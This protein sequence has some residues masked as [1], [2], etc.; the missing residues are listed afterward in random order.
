M[1]SSVIYSEDPITGLVWYWI[2]SKQ[3]EPYINNQTIPKSNRLI[4][5]DHF[6]NKKLRLKLSK[7]VGLF[8]NG[9]IC[10]VFEWFK[11]KNWTRIDLVRNSL[12]YFKK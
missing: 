11:F 2:V 12:D 1:L 7:L 10:R 9:K 8:E 3:L 4:K 5:L 6:V